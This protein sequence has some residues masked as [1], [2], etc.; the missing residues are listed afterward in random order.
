MSVLICEITGSRG[1]SIA[2][3]DNKCVIT[4]DVTL[5]SILTHNA[6]DG[7]KTIFYI[8]VKGIQFKKSGL[9][10][11]Y[12]QLETSSIQM[13]N[14]NS[15]MFSENTFTYGDASSGNLDKLM[16]AVHDYI[17]DRIESYKYG[18]PAQEAYLHSLV[19]LGENNSACNLDKNILSQVKAKLLEQEQLRQQQLERERA[20]KLRKEQEE[21]M[22]L[23]NQL[24]S[25]TA[26]REDVSLV[27]VFLTKAAE[28]T[29][30][31]EI[32]NLWRSLPWENTDSVSLAERKINEA[33]QIERN[34]GR[35]PKSVQRLLSDLV[36]M[37]TDSE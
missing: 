35:T 19:I 17:V 16:E 26:D 7:R 13:N 9:T 29:R 5:G 36:S 21:Q 25:S 32:Q 15:N 12:L 37:L 30:A 14:Q 1:R 4:T 2:V 23:L 31:V 6:L 33:A 11:G 27:D 3:Y 28:C 8:D 10:L 20:E 34:Y 22:K 24:R 18:T